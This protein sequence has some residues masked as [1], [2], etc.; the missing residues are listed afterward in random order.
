MACIIADLWMRHAAAFHAVRVNDQRR[1]DALGAACA[2]GVAA[3]FGTP[4]GG[5]ASPRPGRAP[6]RPPNPRGAP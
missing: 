3:S 4:F 6:R 2:A 5:V 1:L